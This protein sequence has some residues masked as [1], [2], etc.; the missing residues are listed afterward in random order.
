M[1]QTLA[2]LITWS[3]YGTWLHGDERG[4]RDRKNE[5]YSGKHKHDPLL[6]ER[7]RKQLKHEPIVLSP[8]M[9][10]V[11]EEVIREICEFREWRLHAVNVRSNHVHVV[12]GAPCNPEYVL[13]DCKSYATRRLRERGLMDS[14]KT[15]WTRK[16]DKVFLMNE[17]AVRSAVDYTLNR[18]NG[19]RFENGS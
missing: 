9:R 16:G 11:V 5:S 19:Q 4:W 3:T 17:Q 15:V 6:E 7:R 1:P 12:V 8:E 18:Q 14:A 2:Y 10:E 13:R